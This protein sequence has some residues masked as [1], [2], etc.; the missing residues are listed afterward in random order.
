M[1][2]L[3]FIFEGKPPPSVTTYG[4]TTEN[5]PRWYSDYTQGM[6][7]RANA[8]A[9]EGYQPYGGPRIAATNEDQQRSYGLARDAAMAHHPYF[10][11]GQ[12]VLGQ[13]MQT[14][15]GAINQYMDPYIT[16]VTD[17]AAQLTGRALNE[18]LLPGVERMFGAAGHDPRS[19]EMRRTVDRGVRD[20]SEGLQAQNLAALSQ[21]YSQAGQLFGQ[22]QS[23]LLQGA[24]V[25]G[26][27]GLQAQ[28]AGLTGA[29]GL[30][31]IGAQQQQQQQRN[32]DLAYQDFLQQRDYPRETIDWMSSVVRGM[33]YERQVQTQSTGPG[34]TYQPSPLSQL[35]SAGTAAA[36]VG[37]MMGWFNH[38]GRV[39]HPVR[40]ARGGV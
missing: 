17:R 39:R 40:Y 14:F 19:T 11:Q 2:A 34:Q 7:A 23:R 1:G 29:A 26:Q 6:I 21:G 24:G 36:G 31:A 38:G 30:E 37:K 33:P 35:A 16:N 20:L 22:D 18:Q 4:Q 10:Q 28:Q 12:G 8:I 5:M 27:M 25:L 15:P 9:A 13:A 3:D 32:L